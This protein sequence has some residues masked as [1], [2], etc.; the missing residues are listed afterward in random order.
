MARSKLGGLSPSACPSWWC[1]RS[2][3]VASSWV[4]G[5]SSMQMQVM[6]QILQTLDTSDPVLCHARRCSLSLHIQVPRWL[7]RSLSAEQPAAQTLSRE[8]RSVKTRSRRLAFQSQ[9]PS[10]AFRRADPR[11]IC[12]PEWIPTRSHRFQCAP[13]P[14]YRVLVGARASRDNVYLPDGRDAQGMIC[15]WTRH[16][17]AGPSAR[18]REPGRV[19]R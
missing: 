2:S 12:R 17:R 5:L 6:A 18:A 14:R 3:R 1:K 16:R 19:C 11:M 9:C 4:H 13:G 7:V 8:A 10:V 15:V